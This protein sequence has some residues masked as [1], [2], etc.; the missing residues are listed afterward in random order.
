MSLEPKQYPY[1]SHSSMTNENDIKNYG[2]FMSVAYA[3]TDRAALVALCSK[4]QKDYVAKLYQAVATNK[5]TEENIS[6]LSS[7]ADPVKA[8]IAGIATYK[9]IS[10]LT[11]AIKYSKDAGTQHDAII[12]LQTQ[13]VQRLTDLKV[14][15]D[16]SG[17]CLVNIQDVNMQLKPYVEPIKS[18][19]STKSQYLFT[20]KIDENK[21]SAGY[22]ACMVYLWQFDVNYLVEQIAIAT[23][24]INTKISTMSAD[25]DTI[26]SIDDRA[27]GSNSFRNTHKV[28]VSKAELDEQEN[29]DNIKKSKDTVAS[30]LDAANKSPLKWFLVTDINNILKGGVLIT[31][32]PMSEPVTPDKT[33]DINTFL[34]Q[35]RDMLVWRIINGDFNDPSKVTDS[36]VDLLTLFSGGKF[37]R[38]E[39]ID[40]IE[41]K[42]IPIIITK[43][44]ADTTVVFAQYNARTANPLSQTTVTA[45][46]MTQLEMQA[47][48]DAKAKAEYDA[49]LAAAKQAQDDLNNQLAAANDAEKNSLKQQ[50]KD[51]SDSIA[52]LK[53]DQLDATVKAKES[54]QN[55]TPDT[56]PG[57]DITPV[58]IPSI[59]PTQVTAD[60]ESFMDKKIFGYPAPYVIGGGV[61]A[62]GLVLLLVREESKK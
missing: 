44:P 40:S 47:E 55:K 53:Q 7:L 24:A 49:K 37:K 27:N 57:T 41:G 8:A 32:A 30:I 23:D 16:S 17:I 59:Q 38:N 43:Q 51:L 15:G 39:V 46:G 22:W 19:S 14:A 5:I 42:K 3:L 56:S 18:T 33:K 52:Q 25:V 35:S 11:N 60:K 4:Y 48:A 28:A 29:F 54:K 9:D 50:L 13:N 10:Y 12:A 31:D 58:I 26:L 6:F 45:G 36:E 1:F 2:E 20:T 61:A 34:A 21:Y 62:L